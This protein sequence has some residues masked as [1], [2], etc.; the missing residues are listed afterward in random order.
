[1]ALVIK[2]F[3]GLADLNAFTRGLL[4]GSS[5][6]VKMPGSLYLHGRTLIFATPAA[7]VTFAASPA[8]AQVPLTIAQVKAQIEAQ[9]AAAVFVSFNQ[10]ALELR[11]A[12]AGVLVLDKDGTANALLGFDTVTDTTVTPLA[13]PGGGP[14][15]FIS[16]GPEGSQS[17]YLLTY[18]DA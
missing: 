7:T 17:N 13:A 8:A 10:G 2:K 16:V 15:T 18:D 12:P 4:R 11:A 1:M 6:L 3:S 14:P 5:D 9:T